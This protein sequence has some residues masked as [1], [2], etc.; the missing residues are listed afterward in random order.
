MKR[1]GKNEVEK[2]TTIT[3]SETLFKEAE[4]LA[5]LLG[6]TVEQFINEAIEWAITEEKMKREK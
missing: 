1:M 4:K 3:I 2:W 6:C 5:N